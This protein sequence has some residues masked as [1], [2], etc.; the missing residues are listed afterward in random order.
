[1]PTTLVR[2]TQYK[3]DKC[4]NFFKE[5]ELFKPLTPDGGI[6]KNISRCP[7]CAEII[8]LKLKQRR[9]IIADEN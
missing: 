2:I 8:K 4:G 6:E 5:Q 1:M 9:G 3:C 7:M